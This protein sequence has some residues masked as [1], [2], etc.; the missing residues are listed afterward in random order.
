MSDIADAL[1]YVNDKL[2]IEGNVDTMHG[3]QHRMLHN[4]NMLMKSPSNLN[5]HP[6][7]INKIIVNNAIRVPALPKGPL[8]AYLELR[9]GNEVTCKCLVEQYSEE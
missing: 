4:V 6:F 5:Y 8:K 7:H 2:G 3:S 9:E 1:V